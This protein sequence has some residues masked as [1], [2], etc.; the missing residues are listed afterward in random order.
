MRPRKTPVVEANG[1][2]LQASNTQKNKLAQMFLQLFAQDPMYKRLGGY[3]TPLL[4][5]SVVFFFTCLP[6][7]PEV[8]VKTKEIAGT[9]ETEEVQYYRF[10]FTWHHPCIEGFSITVA[11]D[12]P[13]EDF[14]DFR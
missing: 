11:N 7:K 6:L 9:D 10:S 1:S 14:E 3:I 13:V 8:I 5:N 12:V 4:Q 2:A